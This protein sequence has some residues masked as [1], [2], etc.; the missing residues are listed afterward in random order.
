MY[1]D[2]WWS[3]RN[4]NKQLIILSEC[5]VAYLTHLEKSVECV[6]SIV[7]ED[8]VIVHILHI[9]VGD[10]HIHINAPTMV[11]NNGGKQTML[12]VLTTNW[13]S[14]SGTRAPPMIL[15]VGRCSTSGIKAWESKPWND[16]MQIHM[17]V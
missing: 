9:H 7:S 3:T 2:I 14:G 13:G 16:T 4:L 11:V 6:E 5:R 10:I 1:I 8:H 15:C 17:S 12:I